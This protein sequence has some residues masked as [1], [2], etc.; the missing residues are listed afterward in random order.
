MTPDNGSRFS[1]GD[2]KIPKLYYFDADA[3]SLREFV[4]RNKQ[5]L[6]PQDHSQVEQFSHSQAKL[7]FQAGRILLRYLFA[8]SF[9]QPA[10]EIFQTKFGKPFVV[11]DSLFEFNISHTDEYVG[12]AISSGTAIGVDLESSLRK[13]NVMRIADRYFTNQENIDIRLSIDP[14]KYFY[15]LWTLKEAYTKAKGMG[16]RKPLSEIAFSIESG[17]TCSDRKSPAT[18]MQFYS[19]ELARGI[20]MG[21]CYLSPRPEMLEIFTMDTALLSRL[22]EPKLLISSATASGK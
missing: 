13:N 19:C 22:E 3:G 15:Q 20:M 8:E 4:G 9:K 11:N 1:T 2:N 12:V 5:R 17:I 16:L 21:L 6:A 18:Q 7:R 10:I 14:Q